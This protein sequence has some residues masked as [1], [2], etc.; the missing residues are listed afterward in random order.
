M[1]RKRGGITE[2]RASHITTRIWS[3]GTPHNHSRSQSRNRHR[4]Q[5][6]VMR[7]LPQHTSRLSPL[8]ARSQKQTRDTPQDSRC[9]RTGRNTDTPSPAP[10]DTRIPGPCPPYRPSLITRGTTRPAVTPSP[11]LSLNIICNVLSTRAR[12]TRRRCS[13]CGDTSRGDTLASTGGREGRG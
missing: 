9:I 10:K 11:S 8:R 1:S 12:S 7:P 2:A 4:C 6:Y 5:S 13:R 3:L